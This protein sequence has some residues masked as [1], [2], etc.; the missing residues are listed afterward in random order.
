MSGFT[1]FT[2]T[3]SKMHCHGNNIYVCVAIAKGAWQ[4]DPVAGHHKG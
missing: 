2:A 3:I 4:V 1:C